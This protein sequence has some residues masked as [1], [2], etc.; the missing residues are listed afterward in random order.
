MYLTFYGFYGEVSIWFHVALFKNMIFAVV[1]CNIYAILVR[2]ATT[3]KPVCNDHLYDKIH[4]LWLI[5]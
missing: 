4:Y 1:K 3:V 2:M 5:K